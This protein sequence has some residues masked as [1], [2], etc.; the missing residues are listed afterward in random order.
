M[1]KELELTE[2]LRIQGYVATANIGYSNYYYVDIFSMNGTK[3]CVIL[4]TM[5]KGDMLDRFM[6]NQRRKQTSKLI[7]RQFAAEIA[8]KT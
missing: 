2:Q 3:D 5:S 6:F 1:V 7:A 8:G 4:P